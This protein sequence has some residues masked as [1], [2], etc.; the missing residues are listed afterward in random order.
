MW[1]KNYLFSNYV[2]KHKCTTVRKP[3]DNEYFIF[4]LDYEKI[5]WGKDLFFQFSLTDYSRLSPC[6]EMKTI[7]INNMQH[8]LKQNK[9]I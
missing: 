6:V 1:S 5:M 2:L 8:M 9:V 4:I 3:D 7:F